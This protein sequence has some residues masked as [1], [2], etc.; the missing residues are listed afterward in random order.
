ML[1]ID[2]YFFVSQPNPK[3]RKFA[4]PYVESDDLVLFM[5]LI[6]LKRGVFRHLLFNRGYPPRQAL[7]RDTD[8]KKP[9]K[10]E[11]IRREREYVSVTPSISDIY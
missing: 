5:D 6:L 3:C 4:D 8:E 11:V 2:V 7:A 9:A 1:T 10:L